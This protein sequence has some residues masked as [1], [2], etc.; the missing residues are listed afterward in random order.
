MSYCRTWQIKTVHLARQRT[1][2]KGSQWIPQFIYHQW[3]MCFTY[4][5]SQ[6]STPGTTPLTHG[7]LDDI[8][9]LT[10]TVHWSSWP[11]HVPQSSWTH[12]L[13]LI[14]L[15]TGLSHL[16]C[17]MQRVSCLWL[18]ED[19]ACSLGN[20]SKRSWLIGIFTQLLHSPGEANIWYLDSHPVKPLMSRRG[21]VLACCELHQEP[22]SLLPTDA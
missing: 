10:L 4:A 12:Y 14:M 13:S 6:Y 20:L 7:P 15:G 8:K 2:R 3:Y 1:K 21:M 5:P 17:F 16:L 9:D 19:Q 11:G 18:E 22:E